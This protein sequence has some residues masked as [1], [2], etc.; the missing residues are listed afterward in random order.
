MDNVPP[1]DSEVVS[2]MNVKVRHE[3]PSTQTPSLLNIHVMVIPETSTAAAPTILQ[4]IPPITPFPQQ[5]TP[6]P[7]PAP[8]TIT[9]TTSIP[10]LPDFSSLFG[11]DQRVSTL[12]KEVSQF[13]QADYSAQLLE[14]IKS[15]IPAMVDA[16]LS[17]S[18]KILFKR[19]SVKEDYKDEV[20]TQL[21]QILPK[22]ISDFATLVIQSSITE[23]LENVVLAKSSSQPQST[24]EAA[25][26]LIEFELKKILLDKMH[27]DA[28]P[29][30]G[31]KSK[32]SKFS[33]SKG[34]KSQSKSSG[35]T[36]DQPNVEA[37]S[38]DDHFKKPKRPLTLDLDWNATKTIDFRPPQTWISKIAKVEKPP[39]TLD[40]LISTPI[41]F[42]TYVMNNLKIE[43]LTQEHLVR[44]AFNLLKG[45]CK[46]RVEL[47]YHFEECYK[48]VTD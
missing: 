30:K 24:Y 8:T 4:T 39:R 3:E 19:L 46:S 25:T 33:S 43:K 37:A 35:N 18:F 16:Q 13:K 2:M 48:A 22:E 1:T 38:K 31:S 41:D 12:E 17:I 36:D 28:E 34:T 5:S 45:T 29:S 42:S 10:A 11:F 6:T 27:K 47:E 20:N 7:T 23:S 26:S 9:T 21:S 15:Q 40:E 14:M 44:P 32:E